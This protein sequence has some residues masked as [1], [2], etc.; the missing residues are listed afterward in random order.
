MSSKNSEC[1]DTSIIHIQN[2][3]KECGDHFIQNAQRVDEAAGAV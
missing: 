1:G 2:F 3:R